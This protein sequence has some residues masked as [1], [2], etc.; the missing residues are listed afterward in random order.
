[1]EWR[2]KIL[3]KC[4]TDLVFREKVR[5]LFFRDPIFAFNAFFFTYDVRKRPY[6]MQPFCTYEYQD[7]FVLN[8]V[9]DIQEGTA[10]NP[11]DHL[12]EKS[13]DMGVSW[14][15]CL[16]FL[17]FWLDPTGGADFLCGS[18]KEDYVDKKGD[19][20]TLFEK[21]RYALYR[22]PKWLRPKGFKKGPHD[23][24]MNLQNP[25]TGATITGE[26]NNPNFGTGGR[27]KACLLD[28]FAKWESTDEAAW[29]S[30]GDAT[31]CR[32]PVSTPFG[33]GGKYYF[34]TIEGKV[35]MTTMHWTLHPE[36]AAG[37]YCQ[38]PPPN[39]DDKWKLGKDWKPEEKLR[40]PWYD[41]QDK[42]RTPLEM[43]QEIDIDYLGAGNPVFRG[44]AGMALKY[45]RKVKREVI[46]WLQPDISEVS[47]HEVKEPLDKEGY[48]A[49]YSEFDPKLRYVF[50]AD[51]VEGKVT[52]DFA[53]AKV[54]CRETGSVVATYYSHIGED[55]FAFVLKIMQSLYADK[56][57]DEWPWGAPETNG[58]GLATFNKCVDLE[59]RNLFMMPKYELSKEAITYRKGWVT[60]NTSRPLLIAGIRTHL[61]GREG[62]I[63]PRCVNELSTFIFNKNGKAEAKSGCNDDEVMCLGIC[64]QIHDQ[65]PYEPHTAEKMP[66]EDQLGED[67]FDI[68]TARLPEEEREDQSYEA[69]CLAT[70]LEKR[71]NLLGSEEMFYEDD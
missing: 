63:D 8:L 16:V 47:A 14:L 60:N 39:V 59:M 61:E 55:D 26:S 24:Y 36:K 10:E 30:L 23:N 56:A 35:R 49:I 42:R 37:L 6:H 64:I 5:E 34:L 32:V 43:A 65:A 11:T 12:V 54:Y 53:V 38:F 17:W 51:V 18:R 7:E 27:Y 4:K 69:R 68:E 21:I 41:A 52:G 67:P 40:S 9:T 62:F 31:P 22:L 66:R 3:R 44:K 71:G 28:E 15:C 58:P 48:I 2:S 19:M 33:A 20:R 50:G 25:E 29:T 70:A 57:T 46:R 45:Y 1:M 13:R